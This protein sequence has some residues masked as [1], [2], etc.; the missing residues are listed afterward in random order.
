MKKPVLDHRTQNDVLEQLRKRAASY[1]PEWRCDGDESDPGMALA[2]VFSEMYTHT[3]DRFNSLPQ[4]FY[5]EFLNQLGVTEPDVIPAG[6]YVR[7]DVHPVAEHAIPVPEHTL[8]SATDEQTGEGS[9]LRTLIYFK[10]PYSYLICCANLVL[11]LKDHTF[12]EMLLSFFSFCA[13]LFL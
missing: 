13:I 5:T 9:L 4:K 11:T 6:G 1:T 12:V 8:L 10:A 3:L 7:F 2:R